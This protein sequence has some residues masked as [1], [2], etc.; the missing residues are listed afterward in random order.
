M[1]PAHS[2]TPHIKNTQIH[3]HIYYIYIQYIHVGIEGVVYETIYLVPNN[4]EAMVHE[5]VTS[6]SKRLAMAIPLLAT[7]K[8][9]KYVTVFGVEVR[10]DNMRLHAGMNTAPT[11]Y[12]RDRL[13]RSYHCRRYNGGILHSAVNLYFSGY[14]LPLACLNNHNSVFCMAEFIIGG[15][16]NLSTRF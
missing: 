4:I 6:D 3:T 10:V 7:I 2:C 8:V 9:H 5:L 11:F 16:T 14:F 15:H 13:Q 1:L 12:R